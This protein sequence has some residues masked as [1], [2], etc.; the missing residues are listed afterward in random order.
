MKNCR[1]WWKGSKNNL[2]PI[3]LAYDK[4][5]KS[6]KFSFIL[7]LFSELRPKLLRKKM[8][9]PIRNGTRRP[10]YG[11]KIRCCSIILFVTQ[12]MANVLSE[13]G[14]YWKFVPL[15]SFYLKFELRKNFPLMTIS[16]RKIAARLFDIK[17]VVLPC[18][19]LAI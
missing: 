16:K 15:F 13:I 10:W 14:I 7:K 17:N 5:K 9:E 6:N 8:V 4:T 2:N 3:R 12:E 11:R 18:L 19:G 1:K